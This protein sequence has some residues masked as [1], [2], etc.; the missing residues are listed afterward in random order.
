[1]PVIKLEDNYHILNQVAEIEHQYDQ[2]EEVNSTFE[3]LHMV[4]L[5]IEKVIKVHEYLFQNNLHER[6]Y[7]G[8]LYKHK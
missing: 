5:D 8:Y 7:E 4:V 3:D 2:Y 1:M 6:V